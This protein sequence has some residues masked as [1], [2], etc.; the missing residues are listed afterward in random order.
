MT[1][2]LRASVDLV[3]GT[4]QLRQRYGA[5]TA[6]PC[7][8]GHDTAARLLQLAADIGVNAIDTAP[9]YGDAEESIG[10]SGVAL[11]VHTKLAPGVDPE[12]SICESLSRLRRNRVDIAYLHDPTVVL[13][14][15]SQTLLEASAL[16]GGAIHRLGASVYELGEFDAAAADDRVSAIQVPMS[17]LDRRV[18]AERL[19]QAA[20]TGTAVYA[21]SILLQGVLITHPAALPSSVRSL[22]SYVDAF[23][24]TAR[25]LERSPLSAAISWVA[26]QPGVAG[27]VIGAETTRQLRE[28]AEAVSVPL[29]SDALAKLDAI[30]VPSWEMV[31][32]RSWAS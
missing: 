30:P 23:H 8:P 5:I 19:E 1:P 13:N 28:L 6:Q 3:L 15:A 29:S 22:A 2:D 9:A 20:A 27:I 4:A 32:P 24:G 11:P 14:P 26:S 31:D 18:N 10:L 7:D 25:E 21:R 17:V 16:V 12:R